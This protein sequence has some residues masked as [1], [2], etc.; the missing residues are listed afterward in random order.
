M[1]H[2]TT[3]LAT[4]LTEAIPLTLTPAPLG[5]QILL[6]VVAQIISVV[7]YWLSSHI[8]AKGQTGFATALKAWFLTL[9]GLVGVILLA[10]TGVLFGF[11]IPSRPLLMVS[12][13]LGPLLGLIVLFAVPIKLYRL[14]FP[15]AL[16][17]LMCSLL[18]MS[19]GD[20]ALMRLTATPTS[21]DQLN[22]S[23]LLEKTRQALPG[24]TPS[25]QL[26][27]PPPG[28]ATD[29]EFKADKLIATDRVKTISER[30]AAVQR[31]HKGL[32]ARR[33]QLTVEDDAGY[34]LLKQS[35]NAYLQVL[36]A[37]QA[38]AAQRQQAK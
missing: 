9:L 30:Y 31:L 11:T 37:L 7:A 21:F 34:E 32:E 13:V 36:A 2:L 8:L 38:D 25:D 15:G 27:A 5:P 29:K 16:G 28:A 23:Q 3:V 24:G 14:G 6:A 19:A 10:G 12:L 20:L 17:F 22:F 35:R 33:A 18:L 1:F 26:P 4:P